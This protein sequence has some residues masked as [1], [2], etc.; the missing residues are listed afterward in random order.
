M[1]RFLQHF[2]R[3][4]LS[5]SRSEIAIVGC[6]KPVGSDR[7][8]ACRRRIVIRPPYRQEVVGTPDP[9][10]YKWTLPCTCPAHP[11]YP[12]KVGERVDGVIQCEFRNYGGE[13]WTYRVIDCE[14]CRTP[15]SVHEQRGYLEDY[16]YSHHGFCRSCGAD[17]VSEG[18]GPGRWTPAAP[19]GQ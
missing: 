19:S 15:L 9:L 6:C 18:T 2:L 17:Y 8:E 14:V 7:T 4:R 10:S 11:Q 12:F 13:T 16:G 3:A 1:L 5:N